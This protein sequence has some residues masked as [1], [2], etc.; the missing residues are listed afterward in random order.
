M[1][2]K[3]LYKIL[4]KLCQIL[5]IYILTRAATN[6]CLQ[7][8]LFIVGKIA[9]VK[10]FKTN[11]MKQLYVYSDCFLCKKKMLTQTILARTCDL[12]CVIL[13]IF[14]IFKNIKKC[15][16][17]ILIFI[18][19]QMCFFEKFFHEIKVLILFLL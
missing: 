4:P 16:E 18:Q 5:Q 13:I 6:V 8:E 10:N 19:Q 7:K 1:S 3:Q 9:N 14:C 12:K 17:Y 2:R 11:N 15:Y